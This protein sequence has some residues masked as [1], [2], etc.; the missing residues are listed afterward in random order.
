MSAAPGCEFPNPCPVCGADDDHVERMG[1]A[2]RY[3]PA[4]LCPHPAEPG[5]GTGCCCA[6][7]S[8]ETRERRTAGALAAPTLEQRVAALEE[9]LAHPVRLILPSWDPLT[10]EQEAELRETTEAALKAGPYQHR[11]IFQPPP[12]TPVE[13][14]QLVRE[15]VTAVG[16]GETL[17][18][19]GRDWTPGQVREVQDW[20]DAD[21]ES[22]RIDFKVLAVIGDELAVVK[23]EGVPGEA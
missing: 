22:G 1:D 20:M 2:A 21:Y 23:P 17:V 8:R 10:P 12:L 15:C 4:T 14:R 18:I 9:M 7:V 6:G 13:V 19:R 11:V 16:P 5:H 3:S